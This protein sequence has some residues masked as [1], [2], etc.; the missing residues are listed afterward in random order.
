[1]TSLLSF[2]A[3]IRGKP[4]TCRCAPFYAGWGPTAD[5][6]SIPKHRN[7]APD[8]HPLQHPTLTALI[9]AA[10]IAFPRQYDPVSRKLYPPEAVVDR[11]ATC[12]LPKPRVPWRLLAK[13]QGA[14]TSQ[15]HLWR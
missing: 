14:F 1:M 4:V 3:P 10:L 6:G 5:Q 2:E 7:H 8:S 15:F 13:L 12:Q 11:L 9:H